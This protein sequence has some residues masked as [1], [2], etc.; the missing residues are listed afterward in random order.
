MVQPVNLDGKAYPMDS[1]NSIMWKKI[2]ANTFERRTSLNG[3][4]L[5]VR[6][7]HISPDGK[8]LSEEFVRYTLDGKSD[9]R[10][11]E[12]T[13]TSGEGKGLAGTWSLKKTSNTDPAEVRYEPAGQNAVKMTSRMG[14][15]QTLFFDG[16]A[17]PVTG[18]SVIPNMMVSA[19]IIDAN[20]VEM[21]STRE[22]VKASTARMVIS[23]GGKRMTVTSTGTGPESSRE[24]SVT[25]F[26]K[27]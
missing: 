13:R 10:T 21:T 24:P 9:K 26:E 7:I 6:K 27:Q 16:K 5:S 12:Y 23:D 20:T 2:D 17:S 18:A 15:S 4:E 14:V 1:G 11:S 19:K 25:V 3:K 8:S 22:G